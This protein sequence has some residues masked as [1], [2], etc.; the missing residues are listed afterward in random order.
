MMD[1]TSGA[2]STGIRKGVREDKKR[3]QDK[4]KKK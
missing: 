3:C 4:D 2:L 1:G